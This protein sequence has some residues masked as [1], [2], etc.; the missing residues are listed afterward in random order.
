MRARVTNLTRGAMDLHTLGGIV[1]LPAG[2]ETVADLGDGYLA[3]LEISRVVSVDL[4][5]RGRPPK[6][7]G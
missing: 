4:I 3:A 2:G 1:R 7:E 6:T 5:K